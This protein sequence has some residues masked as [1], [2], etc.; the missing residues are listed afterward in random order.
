MGSCAFDPD[1]DAG[2]RRVPARS[3]PCG[4]HGDGLDRGGARGSPREARYAA[5][6][7]GGLRLSRPPGRGALRRQG[8]LAAEPG[9][10]LF[11]AEHLGPAL[12]RGPARE[13]DGGPRD[14]RHGQREGGG[15]ERKAREAEARAARRHQISERR[16]RRQPRWSWAKPCAP[17]AAPSPP[18]PVPYRCHASVRG[19]RAGRLHDVGEIGSRAPIWKTRSDGTSGG[20]VI[21]GV[22]G[23]RV[24][25]GTSSWRGRPCQKLIFSF[26]PCR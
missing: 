20:S 24:P 8:E 23:N 1:P 22:A 17:S 12:L 10:E 7:A 16:P 3:S 26:L 25:V 15:A 4:G 18:L 5:G 6:E 14:L 2:A 19:R 21:S 9:A 13:R 11:P